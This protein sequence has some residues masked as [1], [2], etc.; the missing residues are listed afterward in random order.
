MLVGDQ[1][2]EVHE[3]TLDLDP[4]DPDLAKVA[5]MG[6]VAEHHERKIHAC[7]ASAKANQGFHGLCACPG[8]GFAYQQHAA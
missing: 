3:A 5:S 4:H 1:H 7:K 8:L 2:W 6:Q